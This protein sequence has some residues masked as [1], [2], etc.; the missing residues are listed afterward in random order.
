MKGKRKRKRSNIFFN[1]SNQNFVSHSGMG[2]YRRGHSICVG[3]Q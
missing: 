3:V 2:G 1:F